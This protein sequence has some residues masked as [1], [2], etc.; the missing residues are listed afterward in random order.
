MSVAVTDPADRIAERVARNQA[1]FRDANER[2]HVA[3]AIVDVEPVPFICECPRRECTQLTRLTMAEYEEVRSNGR[4][5]FAAPGHE[6][7]EVD[8]VTIAQL[9]ERRETFSVLEKVGEAGEVALALDPRR[10]EG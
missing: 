6:V 2:I 7:C 8:G 1:T 9:T 3:A 5:F 4:R 10:E